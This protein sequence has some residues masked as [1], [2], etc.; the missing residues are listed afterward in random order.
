MVTWPWRAN[1]LDFILFLFKIDE[2]SDYGLWYGLIWVWNLLWRREL[3][4]WEKELAD[5]LHD[6]LAHVHPTR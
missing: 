1:S 3:Y 5:Q 6:I 2:D 4:H